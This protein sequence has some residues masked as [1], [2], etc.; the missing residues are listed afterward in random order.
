MIKEFIQ[1][2]LNQKLAILIEEAPNSRG[3]V[4]IMHGL[5]GYKEQPHIETMAK[6]FFENNFT[7]VRFDTTN[8]F[9][10]S[11]GNYEDA[12]VTN[13]YNDL[14]DVISWAKGQRWYH[15]PFILV[16]HSTGGMCI[17]LY[18]ENYPKQVMALAP[19]ST[20]LS[21]RLSLSLYSQDKI[22]AWKR[23]G[24]QTKQ[25]SR[26]IVKIKYSHWDDMFK[27]DL[28]SEVGKLIMPVLMIV[29]ECDYT[30]PLEH[31][32]ILYNALPGKKE[33]HII[34]GAPHTFK[35]K[36]HLEQFA[37]FFQHWIEKL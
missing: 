2:R 19:I 17:S 35:D 10:E 36:E 7:A 34:Q 22:D 15:E 16:G 29:G 25:K 21:G 28:L 6:T 26:G 8:T 37:N 23:T 11:D 24:Y 9:G 20:D 33:L 3:L 31:Q 5:G 27:Y 4:F 18:A 30:T 32:Q 1:N 13:Y 14:E 12:T